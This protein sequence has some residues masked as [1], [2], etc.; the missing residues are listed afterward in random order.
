MTNYCSTRA[1]GVKPLRLVSQPLRALG[2]DRSARP[3][4]RAVAT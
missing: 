2:L 4:K 1:F 3:S